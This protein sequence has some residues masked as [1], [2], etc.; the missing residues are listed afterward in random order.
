[1]ASNSYREAARLMERQEA[2]TQVYR[3]L[4]SLLMRSCSFRKFEMSQMSAQMSNLETI[5]EIL[6]FWTDFL[7]HRLSAIRR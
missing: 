2:K 1:M 6:L 3:A 7:A 4:I 5:G